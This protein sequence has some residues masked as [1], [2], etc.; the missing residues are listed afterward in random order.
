[1]ALELQEIDADFDQKHTRTAESISIKL[2][3]EDGEEPQMGS[4][5]G[6]LQMVECPGFADSWQ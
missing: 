6:L 4:I 2:E 5:D 1:M 3:L